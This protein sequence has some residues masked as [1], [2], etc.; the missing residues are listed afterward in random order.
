ML[1]LCNMRV[2]ILQ[3]FLSGWWLGESD[4]RPNEPYIDPA[5]W[6]TALR[7]AGFDGIEAS[8]MDQESPCHLDAMMI[9]RASEPQSF[10]GK[11]L[12][13]LLSE[14]GVVSERVRAIQSRFELAAYD[15]SLC[16]LSNLPPSSTDIVSLL[17]IDESR[18]FFKDISEIRFNGLIRLIEKCYSHGNKI[19][20]ITG[21][22]QISAQD[23]YYAMVLGLARTLRLELGS[24]FATLELEMNELGPSQCDSI[25]QVFRKL[26][27]KSGL[28]YDSMDY[29]FA[30]ANGN[31][32]IPRYITVSTNVLLGKTMDS[33]QSAKRLF[34]KNPGLL[35]SLQWG[36]QSR[37]QTLLDG[38]IEIAVKTASLNSW[39]AL[40]NAEYTYVHLAN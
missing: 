6:D 33:T 4:G 15:V 37:A 27:S 9:A 34:V 25:L 22:A 32:N 19:L 20:W 2:L 12:S 39:V 17:E 21:P 24:V 28:S 18:P 16:T 30:L 14:S 10:S 1:L 5:K 8:I 36:L 38:E 23:P 13:L 31:V 7:N 29:E 11:R 26:Q 40:H 35:Q 3:G